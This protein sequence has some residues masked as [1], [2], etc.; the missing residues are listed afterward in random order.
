MPAGL[1]KVKD[2]ERSERTAIRHI[3]PFPVPTPPSHDIW[4]NLSFEDFSSA[5]ET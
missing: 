5:K 2:T 4:N 1:K 3:V